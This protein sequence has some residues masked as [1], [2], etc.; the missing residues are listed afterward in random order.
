MDSI[1]AGSILGWY[2]PVM[3]LT[4]VHLDLIKANRPNGV[5]FFRVEVLSRSS[6]IQIHQGHRIFFNLEFICVLLLSFQKCT[7]HFYVSET[8]RDSDWKE[9]EEIRHGQEED[10]C[11]STENE[12]YLTAG[13]Q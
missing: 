6:W 4:Y 10:I 13:R 9:T 5:T 8:V 7:S 3:L 11:C 1:F 12:N 2:M